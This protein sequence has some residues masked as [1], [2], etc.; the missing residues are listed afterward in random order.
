MSDNSNIS[1]HWA[2]FRRL[3]I[4]VAI[5]LFLILLFLMLAG[6]SP[7]GNKCDVAPA[8]VEK[9]VEKEK[10]VDNP[11]LVSR[12]S[13]LEKENAEIAGLKSKI[14]DL[15][16]QTG[17]VTGLQAKVKALEAVDLNFDNPKL[18][19]QINLL[20]TENA[21]IAD[22]KKRILE[23]EA[24]SKG[25]AADKTADLT[26]RISELEAENGLIAGLKAKITALEGV[27]VN[28]V[29]PQDNTD[30]LQKIS[31]LEAKNLAIPVLESRLKTLE[32]KQ[33]TLLERIAELEKENGLV[34]GLKAKVKALEAVDVNFIKPK[35]DSAL[36]K[37]IEE[38][39][40][41]KWFN[42]WFKS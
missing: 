15:S 25:S 4:I 30:L 36:L 7:W 29:K 24:A 23:L 2:G 21:S 37:R 28:A 27:D 33:P 42:P 35:D 3:W 13:L 31:G 16:K 6:Y 17:L 18:K 41:G 20:K 34:T 10:L 19:S 22:L 9:V 40:A 14:A 26:K 12:I 11:D 39:E 5:L 38:L 8:V 32:S 1:S